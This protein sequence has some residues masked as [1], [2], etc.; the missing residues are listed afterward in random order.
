MITALV[1]TLVHTATD[2]DTITTAAEAA[3]INPWYLVSFG[4]L[5]AIV[6]LCLEMLLVSGGIL[7]FI[8]LIAAITGA[9]GAFEIHSAFGWGYLFTTPII[10]AAI[11]HWG[12]QR[13]PNSGLAAR[14][15]ITETSGYADHVAEQNITV[16]SIGTLITPAMPTGQASF[17]EHVIDVHAEGGYLE[18][19]TSVRVVAISG[20]SVSVAANHNSSDTSP[21]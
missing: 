6:A 17:D 8:A 21:S 7:G 11:L 12:I 20:T 18:T 1:S 5:I 9:V 19:G 2:S 4:A 13:L 10:A 15:E 16:G 3:Q 14:S